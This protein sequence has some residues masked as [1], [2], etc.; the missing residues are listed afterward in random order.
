MNPRDI[1][2]LYQRELR[3]ALRERTVV[4]NSI[5]IPILLYP[6]LMWLLYT[7]FTFVSGQNEGLPSRVMLQGLPAEHDMLRKEIEGEAGID[8]VA[9]P[10]PESDIRDGK[11]DVLV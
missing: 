10:N 8:L 2:T 4:V 9:S 1:W 3:S 5:L 7:G 6:L 11:L